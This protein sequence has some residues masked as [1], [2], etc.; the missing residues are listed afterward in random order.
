MDD[1]WE[2][3]KA[4]EETQNSAIVIEELLLALYTTTTKRFFH[5][6][7]Q[8]RVAKLRLWN[9]RVS[10]AIN[11]DGLW[12]RLG[13]SL[14]LILTDVEKWLKAY[15]EEFTSVLIAIIYAN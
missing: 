6:F 14:S 5:I 11:W 3:I 2:V 9:L 4:C 1:E 13:V 15:L 7:L 12:L 8:R 10:K